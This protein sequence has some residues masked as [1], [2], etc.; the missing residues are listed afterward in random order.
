MK[1][2]QETLMAYADGELD[3]DTRRAIESAMASDAE[4]AAQVERHRLLKSK[5]SAAFDPVLD[6]PI[7]SR[8][9]EAAKSSP[10]TN[11]P[12]PAVPR[13]PG[14]GTITDLSAARAA[15]TESA[16]KRNWSWPEWT[17]I[18][19]SLLIGLFAGRAVLQTPDSPTSST[20]VAT[21]NGEIVATGALAAALSEQAGGAQGNSSVDIGLSF[22]AKSGEYCRTFSARDT[23]ALAG[24]AC[25]DADQWR[26]HALTQGEAEA[27]GGDYR[28]AGTHLPPLIRQAVE[29]AID[30]EALDAEQE[31]AAR[32][33]GWK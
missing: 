7:P 29:G 13:R 31:A 25:R 24:V 15:K 11:A 18:A 16:R 32:S 5:L 12:S 1:F 22:R 27:A 6:E 30:G 23:G 28:M 19:A 14:E 3:A 17:S 4:V 8:L 2:S 20:L 10:A 21:T 26:V 33:R 9:L